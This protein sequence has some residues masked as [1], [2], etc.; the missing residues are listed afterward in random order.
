MA[1]APSLLQLHGSLE[2]RNKPGMLGRCA[3]GHRQGRGD[4]GAVDLVE[5]SGAHV[6]RDITI[7]AGQAGMPTT[8]SIAS[9]ARPG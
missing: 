9:G 3:L 8:S 2:I 6:L 1:V 5:M 4:I 7:E